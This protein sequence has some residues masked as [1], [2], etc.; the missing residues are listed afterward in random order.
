VALTNKFSLIEEDNSSS[1]LSG[2]INASAVNW[3]KVKLTPS[4]PVVCN[5]ISV[6]LDTSST[7]AKVYINDISIEYRV[8]YRKGV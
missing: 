1:S 2:T 5:K 7:S 4:S 3:A 6:Q 8:I